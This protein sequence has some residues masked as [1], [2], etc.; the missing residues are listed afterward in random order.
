[1]MTMDTPPAIHE[2]YAFIT[3]K[4]N[5]YN[6]QFTP[7]T[8]DKFDYVPNP[9]LDMS[10]V[11]NGAKVKDIMSGSILDEDRY[12]GIGDMKIKVDPE[13][14]L[15][16]RFDTK[17]NTIWLKD[18]TDQNTALHEI[19]HA[20]DK[21]SGTNKIKGVREIEKENGLPHNLRK[22]EQ[23]TKTNDILIEAEKM[24]KA[25][26]TG[27]QV[28]QYFDKKIKQADGIDTPEAK[29]LYNR[30]KS[31]RTLFQRYLDENNSLIA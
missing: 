23:T 13:M 26:K 22:I 25:G 15:L 31:A 6:K 1:M 4:D 14:T 7:D 12:K 28:L 20:I 24:M 17:T 3:P 18:S 2:E 9:D 21:K 30:Y 16:G 11:K 5:G 8:V 19:Q 29:A 10:K 27:D